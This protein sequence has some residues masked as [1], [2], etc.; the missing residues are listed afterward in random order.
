[1]SSKQTMASLVWE[2]I[3][4]SDGFSTTEVDVSIILISIRGTKLNLFYKLQFECSNNKSEYKVLVLSRIAALNMEVTLLCVK[5]DSNAHFHTLPP[6]EDLKNWRSSFGPPLESWRAEA[7]HHAVMYRGQVPTIFP[8][9]HCPAT[10]GQSSPSFNSEENFTKERHTLKK[11]DYKHHHL[12]LKHLNLTANSQARENK[13]GT[14]RLEI[15]RRQNSKGEFAVAAISLPTVRGRICIPVSEFGTGWKDLAAVLFRLDQRKEEDRRKDCGRLNYVPQR[16]DHRKIREKV[17]YSQAASSVSWPVMHCEILPLVDGAKEDVEVSPSSCSV[18]PFL[19]DQCLVGTLTDW[20]GAVPTSNELERW[21]N[22]EWGIGTPVKVKDMNGSQYMFIL[23]SKAEVRSVRNKRWKFEESRLELN[24]WEGRCGCFEDK[25]KPETQVRV[26]GLPVFLWSEELFRALG[27]R[28]GG[29][30]ATATETLNR[31]HVKWARICIRG[32]IFVTLATVS[33]GMGSLAYVCPIWVE[34]GARVVRRSE[35]TRYSDGARWREKMGKEAA[36]EGDGMTV[37]ITRG[38]RTE[39]QTGRGSLGFGRESRVPIKAGAKVGDWGVSRASGRLGLKYNTGLRN[40]KGNLSLNEHGPIEWASRKDNRDWER[41]GAQR[42]KFRGLRL[43]NWVLDQAQKDGINA[44]QHEDYFEA[45]VGSSKSKS[46][47]E[48][49]R[50]EEANTLSQVLEGGE[51]GVTSGEAN[52]SRLGMEGGSRWASPREEE[53]GAI[54]DFDTSQEMSGE[55]QSEHGN[56]EGEFLA[57]V[58]VECSQVEPIASIGLG[59][60]EIGQEVEGDWFLGRGAQLASSAW[61]RKKPKGFCG[62]LEVDVKGG[63]EVLT[64]G[65]EL[66]ESSRIWNDRCPTGEGE[67]LRAEGTTGGI[68]IMWDTRY[69]T[70]LDVLVGIHSISCLFK[71]VEE[72]NTWAFA[73]VYGPQNKGDRIGLWEELAGARAAWGTMWVCGGD[74]NVVRFPHER[75]G[76]N[77]F[78]KAMRDFSDY[79]TEEELIDL[80]LEGDYFTWSNGIAQSRLD[81]FLISSEWEG[82]HMDVRQFCLPRV[83]SDHKPVF[84]SGGGMSRGPASFRFEN[85]WLK[86]EGFRDL[87]KKWWEGYEVHGSPSYRLA[88]KLRALKED[89]K[90][91]NREVFGWVEIR[92]ATLTEELQNLEYKD[93]SSGLFEEERDRGGEVRAKIGRLLIAEETSWRQKS[94]AIW[95]SE[96]DR[97]T[98]FFHHVANAHRRYNYNGKIRVD[99]ALH[100]N[101][102]MLASGIVG[103]YGKLY[104]EPE[105]WRP[106]VAGLR[107]PSLNMEEM[108][109]LERPFWEEEVSEVVMGLRGDKAPGPDGFTLAFLQ[110]CWSM[111]KDDIMA[112]FEQFHAEGVFEKSLNAAFIVL[113]LKKNGAVDIG[114][115]R[116]ISLIGC[117]YKVLAKVLARR[118][119]KVMDRLITENHNA[120]VGRRQ[121]LDASLVANECVDVR[122]KSKEPGVLCKL[123]IEKAYDHEEIV[124]HLMFADDTLILCKADSGELTCLKDILLCFQAV[125]G[126]KINLVKSELIQVGDGIDLRSLVATLGCKSG[127]F[128]TTYLGL[129]LGSPYKSKTVG[130]QWWRDLRGG[131]L[132]GGGNICQKEVLCYPKKGGGLGIRDLALFNKAL[133]R[134]WIWRF[135]RGEDKLW[136]RVI[137]GKYGTVRGDWRSKDIIQSHGT[138]IWKGIMKI[139]GD[140]SSQ[141][142]RIVCLVH[143]PGCVGGGLLVIFAWGG[144]LGSFVLKGA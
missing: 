42:P 84:L 10:L 129:P 39:A 141:I 68:L 60:V 92:L 139:W 69:L 82:E 49:D 114:D 93:Q 108:E 112:V 30:I 63:E 25:N 120:F 8:K 111:V 55:L 52:I 110:H 43:D 32:T 88:R 38:R 54:E 122:L 91:W 46:P 11:W 94:R 3:L 77:L 41:K 97:N 90:M 51:S 80:P 118:I 121:I 29:Y 116:P 85:M 131:L 50:I 107:L 123:D 19:R 117:I 22:A 126:L 18:I 5:G 33:V 61:A 23:P 140:F 66:G 64:A 86:V 27:E 2:W 127:S 137:E 73:G 37:D 62:E 130:G 24:V 47:Y 14:R 7:L 142:P 106:R 13:F 104:R 31:E 96:G 56:R 21:C 17:T 15:F 113:I 48:I 72:G 105:Q 95:L 67:S 102:D 26:L 35:P 36:G 124:P 98:A 28:C 53:D 45:F 81:R 6:E 136:C 20:K 89:L 103:F 134:K 115:Y 109:S 133:L 74:F 16:S 78:S 99:G 101:Q 132:L 70:G 128:P 4:S 44:T 119:A 1:M 71:N 40:N 143:L 76:G 65:A 12:L 79:I 87:V 75:A 138:G 9:G 100:E 144:L 83:V 135:A 125:S 59:V 57:M 34:S 58:P